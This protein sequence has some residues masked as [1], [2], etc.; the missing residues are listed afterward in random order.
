[1]NTHIQILGQIKLGESDYYLLSLSTQK[2]TSSYFHL[3]RQSLTLTLMNLFQLCILHHVF[4][5]I[6]CVMCSQHMQWLCHV[7]IL[8]MME[9]K[10][11][12]L[13]SS[14]LHLCL[15]FFCLDFLLLKAFVCALYVLYAMHLSNIIILWHVK[16]ASKP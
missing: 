9:K 11:P 5:C 3:V 4:Y 10:Q 7:M 15:L 1:M 6:G 8:F 2:Q 16:Y 14:R 12:N 13:F